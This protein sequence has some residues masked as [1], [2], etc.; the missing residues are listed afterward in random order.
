[1]FCFTRRARWDVSQIRCIY[2]T[3]PCRKQPIERVPEKQTEKKQEGCGFNPNFG[4]SL[5]V[6]TLCLCLRGFSPSAPASSHIPSSNMHVRWTGNSKL[7]VWVNVGMD[8]WLCFC[9]AGWTDLN[10]LALAS[11][12]WSTYHLSWNSGNNNNIHDCT[13]LFLSLT[14]SDYSM[15]VFSWLGQQTGNTIYG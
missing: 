14:M 15:K 1:M 6:C 2:F 3:C 12:F 10:W 7:E 8:G 4:L 13:C 11:Q 9:P 5:W